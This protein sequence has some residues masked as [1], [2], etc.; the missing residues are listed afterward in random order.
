MLDALRKLSR[1]Q[2]RRREH[3]T[4]LSLNA[5][6]HLRWNNRAVVRRLANSAWTSPGRGQ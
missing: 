1:L 5:L 3:A 6:W 2:L 4:I